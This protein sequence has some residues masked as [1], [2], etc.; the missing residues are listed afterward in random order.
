MESPKGSSFNQL[1]KLGISLPLMETAANT[2]LATMCLLIDPY[3]P[4]GKEK[5]EIPQRPSLESVL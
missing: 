5:C 4:G 1:E 2:F 3:R